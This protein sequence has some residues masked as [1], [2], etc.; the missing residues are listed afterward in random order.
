MSV[1]QFVG[2]MKQTIEEIKAQGTTTI[3]CDNLID[4][5]AEIQKAPE[6]EPTALQIEKYKADLQNWVETIKQNHEG[7]LEMFRS[8]ITAGQ[9]AIKTTFLLNGGASV[10][11]LA[12]IGH[13]AQFNTSKIPAFAGCLVIFAYGV[14]A[15]A[16]TSGL[17]YLSQWLYGGTSPAAKK[18]GFVLNLFCML[19]GVSSYAFFAWGLFKAYCA[20]LAYA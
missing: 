10:A 16:V 1:K 11:M 15:I 4:Y 17:T 3:P 18:A 8:V 19:L 5:L 20:F 13:L 7:D 2:Q 14:L 9:T 6:A 12:F